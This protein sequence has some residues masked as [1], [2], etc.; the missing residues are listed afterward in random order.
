A[1][2]WGIDPD[3]ADDD[4][5]GGRGW[6]EGVWY[7]RNCTVHGRLKGEW[8]TGGP[9]VGYFGGLWARSCSEAI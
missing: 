7:G 4:P 2:D 1:G 9:G 6:F 5:A 8:I 3:I